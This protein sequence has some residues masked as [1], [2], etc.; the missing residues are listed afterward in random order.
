MFLIYIAMLRLELGRSPL[1]NQL[2]GCSNAII[3]RLH[4]CSPAHIRRNI[5]LSSVCEQSSTCEN[6][7]SPGRV[8][9]PGHVRP[10]RD[11]M[12]MEEDLVA[13]ASEDR[14]VEPVPISHILTEIGVRAKNRRQNSSL[15]GD[16]MLVRCSL[17][18][19]LE[20]C[21]VKLSSRQK[22]SSPVSCINI[23]R[24]RK[25]ASSSH[26]TQSKSSTRHL[27]NCSK[28]NPVNV[29]FL[30]RNGVAGLGA[31]KGRA[32]SA[33]CRKQASP[34]KVVPR[35]TAVGREGGARE[36]CPATSPWC[37]AEAADSAHRH[38]PSATDCSYGRAVSGKK[39]YPCHLCTKTFGWSTDLKRHILTHTGER[40]FKCGLCRATFTRNFLL[41]KHEAKF[42][43]ADV[44]TFALGGKDSSSSMNGSLLS[45]S[46]LVQYKQGVASKLGEK[47]EILKVSKQKS[48][49]TKKF[50][51]AKKSTL[52]MEVKPVLPSK[53][54]S[55][56]A[57]NSS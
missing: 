48:K 10:A 37:E 30:M 53:M 31:G 43:D 38:V 7:D 52:G 50:N 27:P 20:N 49:S 29:C 26:L 5:K 47:T 28:S 15:S 19:R 12:T 34:R 2:C 11:T 44:Q 24:D 9:C 56:E 6:C 25:T 40:P 16:F 13:W 39:K 4:H 55:S 17:Q 32:K 46:R 1:R 22:N 3:F 8:E 35:H 42:H 57:L 14:Q 23:S 51:L 45:Q 36:E 41:Q 18:R 21:I 33:S 54:S